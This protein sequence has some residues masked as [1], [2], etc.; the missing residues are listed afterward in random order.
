[1][2]RSPLVRSLSR[3]SARA[4][5][6]ASDASRVASSAPSFGIAF[7]IDGVLIRWEK[8]KVVSIVILC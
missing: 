4:Y 1:M 5:S 8:M 2:W 7:D 3:R 6:V